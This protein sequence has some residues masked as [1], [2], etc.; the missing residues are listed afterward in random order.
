MK[1]KDIDRAAKSLLFTGKLPARKRTEPTQAQKEKKFI[2]RV[3]RNGQ[4]N[5]KEVG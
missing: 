1:Q 3:D 5:V 4:R 2:M